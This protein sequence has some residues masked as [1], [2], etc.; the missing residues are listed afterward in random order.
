MG[1][2]VAWKEEGTESREP[3]SASWKYFKESDFQNPQ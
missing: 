2:A 1:L 3:V